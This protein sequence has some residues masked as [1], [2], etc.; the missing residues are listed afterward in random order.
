MS[1]AVASALSAAAPLALRRFGAGRVVAEPLRELG[2][3]ARRRQA[4]GPALLLERGQVRERVDTRAE[5]LPRIPSEENNGLI[6]GY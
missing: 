5:A 1:I 2:L 6:T 3:R 4:V